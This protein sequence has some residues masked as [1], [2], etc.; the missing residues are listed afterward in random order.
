[1]RFWRKSYAS[2]PIDT[3]N[4][5]CITCS[6]VKQGKSSV[7]F[8][9]AQ[10]S[11]TT[12]PKTAKRT[13]KKILQN[14]DTQ[15]K[16][17]HIPWKSMVGNMRFLVKWSLFGGTFPQLSGGVRIPY[18]KNPPRMWGKFVPLKKL[19]GLEAKLLATYPNLAMI[20]V[21]E[22]LWSDVL[23]GWNWLVGLGWVWHKVVWHAWSWLEHMSFFLMMMKN[24][25][26]NYIYKCFWL[27]VFVF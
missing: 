8:H 18:R 9:V 10:I 12:A 1:M 24:M 6:D 13:C 27:Y 2:S 21:W 22:A 11:T 7:L 17:R 25:I 14:C 3:D 5:A 19:T 23:L 16:N 20:F 15:E 26:F 4:F